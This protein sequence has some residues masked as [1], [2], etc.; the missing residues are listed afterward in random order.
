VAIGRVARR[1]VA[2]VPRSFGIVVAGQIVLFVGLNVPEGVIWNFAIEWHARLL[3]EG[4]EYSRYH[5]GTPL[6]P[7]F[8]PRKRLDNC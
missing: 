8:T 5:N 7:I 3:W 1:P 2:G 6:A 4:R